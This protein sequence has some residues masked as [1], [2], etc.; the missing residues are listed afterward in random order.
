MGLKLSWPVIYF[1]PHQCDQYLHYQG[2]DVDFCT[3]L[4]PLHQTFHPW[5]SKEALE[6]VQM[7]MWSFLFTHPRGI[8]HVWHWAGDGQFALCG[9]SSVS[10]PSRVSSSRVVVVH[11][12]CLAHM[13]IQRGVPSV[14][15]MRK[16]SFSGGLMSIQP[17]G[18]SWGR[19]GCLQQTGTPLCMVPPSTGPSLPSSHVGIGFSQD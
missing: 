11:L 3:P 7:N 8:S 1:K 18:Y 14:G 4:I 15:V 13:T 2:S 16:V 12:A 5:S 6:N 19:K 17:A 10:L 9:T